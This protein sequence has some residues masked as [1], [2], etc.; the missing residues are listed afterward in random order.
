[1]KL[2]LKV[3]G[4]AVE[5]MARHRLARQ[6]AKLCRSGAQVVLVHGGGKVLT[7]TL[8]RMGVTTRFEDGLRVT[9]RESRDVALMVLAGLIN[10]Q[11]VSSLQC[12]G[13]AALG[14]CG[15]DGKLVEARKLT[16]RHGGRSRNLGFVGRPSK[17]RVQAIEMAW[18]PRASI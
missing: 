3:G 14:L 16:L 4:A 9:D 13:Q 6:V 11:W 2:V 8:S 5:G 12:E 18:K 17:V 1:V 15:G 10:K 7:G